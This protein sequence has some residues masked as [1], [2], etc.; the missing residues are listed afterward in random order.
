MSLELPHNNHQLNPNRHLILSS[1]AVLA[2]TGV[3]LLFFSFMSLGYATRSSEKEAAVFYDAVSDIVD[4]VWDTVGWP[5]QAVASAA[6]AFFRT[7][8]LPYHFV[9]R[10]VARI[11]YTGSAAGR[12][13]QVATDWTIGAVGA[14]SDWIIGTYSAISSSIAMHGN[15]VGGVVFGSVSWLSNQP[16]RA[17]S[18]LGRAGK[19]LTAWTSSAWAA[20]TSFF[21][22][23]GSSV[24][25][26]FQNLSL[27]FSNTTINLRRET[28]SRAWV[29]L[30]AVSNF[31][32][33]CKRFLV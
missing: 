24:G 28:Y 9:Q 11:E 12:A 17:V 16:S 14:S 32:L 8:L 2:I 22:G 4:K 6:N 23:V 27:W 26:T 19:S 31:L 5:F 13:L 20:V 1:G 10:V 21:G 25:V 7:V 29:A 30:G 15:A 3:G 33:S 18:S